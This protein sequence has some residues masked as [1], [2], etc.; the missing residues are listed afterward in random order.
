MRISIILIV[1]L[2]LANI[3]IAQ[4]NWPQ[5]G[6]KWYYSYTPCSGKKANCDMEEYITIEVIKD[7]ILKDTVC[8]ELLVKYNNE[9]NVVIKIGT[10]FIYATTHQV[11]NYHHGQFNLLYDF[12]AE[13]GDTLDL[14]I[15]TNSKIHQKLYGFTNDSIWIKHIIVDK[16][17]EVINGSELPYIQ[18]EIIHDESNYDGYSHL[19]SKKIIQG[20]GDLTFLFG[21][22]TIMLDEYD[23]YGPLRCYKDDRV[24][25]D[26]GIAC[27]TIQPHWSSILFQVGLKQL[28]VYPNP[29]TDYLTIDFNN[30]SCQSIHID[31]I[32]GE[33]KLVTTEQL[34]DAQLIISV[35]HLQNGLY[36]FKVSSESEIIG[37]GK[38]V[39]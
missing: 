29:V 26:I 9:N 14:L 25:Y 38:F 15:S 21:E 7:T 36:F 22:F 13:V 19:G 39:K 17:V 20:I 32:N 28:N 34:N 2:N 35:D 1:L 24:D 11:Y 23:I 33:G 30:E 31:V 3:S 27:D 12:M 5:M 10:E 37:G 16:G 4:N 6:A 18:H 8:K